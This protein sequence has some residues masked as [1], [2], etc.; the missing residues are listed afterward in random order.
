MHR[1]LAGTDR[2]QV[3]SRFVADLEP[4]DEALLVDLLGKAETPTGAAAGESDSAEP[5]KHKKRL[6]R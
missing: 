2:A 6:R 3:L 5:P 4:G 1:L